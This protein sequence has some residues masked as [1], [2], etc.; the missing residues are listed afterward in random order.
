MIMQSHPRRNT[1][2]Y[3]NKGGKR[4]LMKTMVLVEW[5]QDKRLVGCTT[6]AMLVILCIMKYHSVLP[7]VMLNTQTFTNKR[8]ESYQT[9]FFVIIWGTFSRGLSKLTG[10]CSFDIDKTL[11]CINFLDFHFFKTLMLVLQWCFPSPGLLHD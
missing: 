4:K 3:L 7:A 9:G 1:W 5:T 11:V 2:R 10:W 8:K 6:S